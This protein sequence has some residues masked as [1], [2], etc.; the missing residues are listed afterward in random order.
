MRHL[1]TILISLFAFCIVGMSYAK[2]LKHTFHSC[3][4]KL[5]NSVGSAR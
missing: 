3:G 5:K 1:K 2:P 4:F